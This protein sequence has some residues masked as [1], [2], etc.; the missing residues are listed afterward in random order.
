MFLYRISPPPTLLV[1]R[2]GAHSPVFL[3][4]CLAPQLSTVALGFLDDDNELDLV[5]TDYV[6]FDIPSQMRAVFVIL[7]V[8]HEVGHPV[9]LFDKHWIAIGEHFV[10]RLSSEEH[11]LSDKHLMMLVLLDINTRL[12]AINTHVKAFNLPMRQESQ[13]QVPLRSVTHL[14]E[15]R[16]VSRVTRISVSQIRDASHALHV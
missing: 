10:H 5:M 16:G 11:P 1:C 8:F 14:V 9:G 15:S 13:V 2:R 7:L 3:L 4:H 6:A 12:E